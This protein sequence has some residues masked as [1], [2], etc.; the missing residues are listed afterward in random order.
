MPINERMLAKICSPDYSLVWL[1]VS[2][3]SFGCFFYTHTGWEL[4]CCFGSKLLFIGFPFSSL[5]EILVPVLTSLSH[6][7]WSNHRISL[8]IT[9][10]EP[11]M[12]LYSVSSGFI[13]SLPISFQAKRVQSYSPVELRENWDLVRSIK[14]FRNEK[15]AGTGNF[16]GNGQL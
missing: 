6:N 7:F 5:G 8:E 3:S 12:N 1:I 16:P 14:Y 13:I 4:K 2:L 11:E 9:F 15:S 10:S